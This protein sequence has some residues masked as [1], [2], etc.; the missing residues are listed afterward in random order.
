[1]KQRILARVCL[2]VCMAFSNA[3]ADDEQPAGQA[4]LSLDDLRTFTDVFNQ[5]RSNFVEEVDDITLLNA[6]I[7][8]MLTELDRY[9]IFL[10][11]GS[12]RNLDDSSRGRYGGI[13]AAVEVRDRRIVVTELLENGPASLA[14]VRVG[15]LVTAIDG[16]AVRGRRLSES[17]AELRGEPGTRVT[18][19]FK[20]PGARSRKL[21]LTRYY[22]PVSSVASE[23][24][25]HDYGYLRISHFHE[26]SHVEFE[27]SLRLLQAGRETPLQG[28]ILDL[29]QNLGGVLQPA[30]AIADGFLDAGLIVY[31][32]SRYQ[33]TQLKFN[34][35]P[36]QWAPGV[37][38]AVLVD[39]ETASASEVLAGALQDHH[40]AVIVGRKT[41]GKGSVQSVLALRN[42]T[43]LKLTTARY[44]TPSGKS[45]HNKGIEP[46]TLIE[47]GADEEVLQKALELLKANTAP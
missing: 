20:T 45:I 35:K 26:G 13:G 22:V 31:T 5:V 24:L 38:L 9:S 2:A 4:Q 12:F 40:R 27:D 25:D 21:T 46:D 3:V 1:M 7:R 19:R 39:E 23:I 44:F 36:G 42:G 14:G 47:S 29:R 30:V 43:A 37:P 28:I 33:A 15:D 6:A 11:A 18:V 34:A 16:H 10:E 41:F 8:G 32:Q 17:M